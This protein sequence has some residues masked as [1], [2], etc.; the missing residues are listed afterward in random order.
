M[1]LRP[2]CASLIMFYRAEP[3]EYHDSK[4]TSS[5]GPPGEDVKR[6]WHQYFELSEI[7]IGIRKR[8]IDPLEQSQ[9]IFD[10]GPLVAIYILLLNSAAVLFYFL[11][12][13]VAVGIL[14][15]PPTALII[16]AIL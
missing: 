12:W 7:A 4:R 2:P 5:F 6:F 9:S 8:L 10:I 16:A 14:L 13:R 11:K 15:T 1:S 3:F